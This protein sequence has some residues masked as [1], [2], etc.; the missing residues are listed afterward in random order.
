[1]AHSAK[2]TQEPMQHMAQAKLSAS[3]SESARVLHLKE[4]ALERVLIM[5]VCSCET[6]PGAVYENHSD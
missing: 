5:M 2:S 6:M 4:G 3:V 1:M